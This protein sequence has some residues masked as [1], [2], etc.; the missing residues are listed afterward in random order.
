MDSTWKRTAPDSDNCGQHSPPSGRAAC[1]PDKPNCRQPDP[2]ARSQSGYG[3]SDPDFLGSLAEGPDAHAAG[4]VQVQEIMTR[5]LA[6]ME[7]NSTLQEAAEKMRICNVG[8]LPVCEYGRPVGVL[9][10]RD[11]AIRATAAGDEPGKV[12]VR[13]IMTRDLHTCF[14][15]QDLPAVARL[16]Q[17]KQI[18]RILVTDHDGGLVGIVSLG[19]LAI[20][21]DSV[22]CHR[23]S[24]ARILRKKAIDRRL[25]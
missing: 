17:E 22:D 4:M 23:L 6:V 16:M 25:P 8:L 14:L 9:T 20:S 2:P 10:D 11:I 5:N 7:L 1:A 18:R 12:R 15:D 24:M 21:G 19:D 3:L 13:D